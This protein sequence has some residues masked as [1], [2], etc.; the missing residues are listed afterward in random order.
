MVSIVNLWFEK[1]PGI[2]QRDHFGSIVPLHTQKY[3]L[4]NRYS[5]HNEKSFFILPIKL[6]KN[7]FDKY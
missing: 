4:I 2:V 7:F 5:A 1:Y 6:V 3:G